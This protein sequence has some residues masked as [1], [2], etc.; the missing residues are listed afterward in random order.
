MKII[1][2]G[3]GRV[4]SS[5][6]EALCR[7]GHDI[8]VIDKD[9][10][11]IDHISVDAD[12]ICLEGSVT[13][14][15]MLAEAGAKTADL[16]IAATHS[17]EINLVCG[18]S[19]SRLGTKHVIARVRDPEYIGK[20][21]FLQETFGI[22]LAVNPELES[23]KEISRI[24]RF[25]GA[26][27]VDSFSKGSAEIAEHRIP[28]ESP[29]NGM[30][31]KDLDGKF[32]AK[33]LIS[34]VERDGEAFIPNGQFVLRTD[35]RL[36][37]LGSPEE[38]KRFLLAA[39][40]YQRTVRSVIIMG[41]GRLS[42]YLT[43][44]LCDSGM[45]VSVIE[46]NRERCDALCDLIPDAR[47]ICGDATRSDVLLE[48]KVGS[49][50]AFIALTGDDGSNIIT[51][52]YADSCGAGKTVVKVNH[53]HFADMIQDSAIDSVVIPKEVA[54][55]QIIRYVR[56]LNN[57]ADSSKIETLYKL[58]D[59]AAEAIEFRITEDTGITGIPLKDLKLKQNVL[60]AGLI[61]NGR[62]IVP[63]GSTEL[64]AGDNAVVVTTAGW[65]TEFA[66]IIR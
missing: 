61:R 26:S 60:I 9:E 16:L 10:E 23:A 42:V 29:L 59:G 1:I 32:G 38:L 25:P 62:F 4:G 27:R 3:A 45:S 63:N 41:G 14:S 56:A 51:A 6:A 64:Q 21:Q 37:I 13:D 39:G 43:R 7:E 24:L 15:D 44:L 40:A 49:A 36:S 28:E 31:L 35:D 5:L 54:T 34:L 2:A 66:G 33:I 53:E 65:L 11:T 20:G 47:I 58:A 48:E 52:M 8:A 22:S 19:A 50:D 30:A 57:S 18:I 55:Q 46:E 17:D 12:V